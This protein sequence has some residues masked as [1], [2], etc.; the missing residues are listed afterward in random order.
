M[1]VL[2]NNGRLR[3]QQQLAL[4]AVLARHVWW[5][6]RT[7]TPLPL[8]DFVIE[9]TCGAPK[10][11]AN[12]KFPILNDY[13]TPASV[14]VKSGSDEFDAP[15]LSLNLVTPIFGCAVRIRASGSMRFE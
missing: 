3:C 9:A 4:G 11:V 1:A 5:H 6:L 12:V 8:R 2:I 15:T 7:V 10:L 13:R 14:A